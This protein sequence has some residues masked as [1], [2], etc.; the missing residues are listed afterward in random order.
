MSSNET[1][2]KPRYVTLPWGR[3]QV[4]DEV[5]F[6]RA[7]ADGRPVCVG[8][9]HLRDADGAELVRFFYRSNGYTVRGPLTL[10]AADRLGLKAALAQSPALRKLVRELV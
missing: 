10:R 6:E 2:A 4:I 9:A 8:V 3:A 7:G 5:T 1:T